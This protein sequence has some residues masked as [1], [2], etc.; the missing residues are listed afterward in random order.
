M[1]VSG[2]EWHGEMQ[3]ERWRTGF[4]ATRPPVQPLFRGGKAH[5]AH[6]IAGR[7]LVHAQAEFRQQRK[8]VVKDI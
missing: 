1:P 3:R 6:I 4:S 5:I 2:Y 7:R 8:D